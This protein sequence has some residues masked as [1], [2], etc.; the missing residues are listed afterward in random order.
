MRNTNLYNITW[1]INFITYINMFYVNISYN[2][3]K[4]KMIFSILLI[5]INLE[6]IDQTF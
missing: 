4:I 3:L 2:D 6:W 5:L 1:H